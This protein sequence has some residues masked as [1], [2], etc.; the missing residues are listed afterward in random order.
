MDVV[1][2]KRDTHCSVVSENIDWVD[3]LFVSDGGL[4][5]LVTSKVIYC[6]SGEFTSHVRCHDCAGKKTEASVGYG[7]W[8]SGLRGWYLEEV[9]ERWPPLA[10]H[11]S[12]SWS[13]DGVRNCLHED[14]LGANLATGVRCLWLRI[15]IRHLQHSDIRMME[16]V[17]F[18]R[19]LQCFV[20]LTADECGI[21]DQINSPHII[22]WICI[23][24]V[25]VNCNRLGTER[26][27]Y[28]WAAVACTADYLAIA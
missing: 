14:S 28:L 20:W 25:I 24:K 12:R 27:D 7:D 11:A 3:F 1:E 5:G 6:L 2:R 21:H 8:L 22:R 17:V 18:A 9:G 15:V 26:Y 19:S 13:G 10:G 4:E 23:W 16:D